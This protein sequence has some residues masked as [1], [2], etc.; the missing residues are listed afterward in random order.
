MSTTLS[1]MPA[2]GNI[3]KRKNGEQKG[4]INF[5]PVF[6]PVP[7]APVIPVPPVTPGG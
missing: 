7:V 2:A 3:K 4:R 5:G 6:G 1:K